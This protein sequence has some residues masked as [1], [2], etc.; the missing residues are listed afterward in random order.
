MDNQEQAMDETR[1]KA[2]GDASSTF[3]FSKQA[4]FSLQGRMLMAGDWL[5]VSVFGQWI[6]GRVEVD[7]GG[8][9][10]QTLDQVGIRLSNGLR[11]RL[12][13]NPH[14]SASAFLQ[15]PASCRELLGETNALP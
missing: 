15:P 13:V 6:A 10:L 4:P 5:E 2:R 14:V 11:A 9:Y 7:A 12:M 1:L 8:W 3:F